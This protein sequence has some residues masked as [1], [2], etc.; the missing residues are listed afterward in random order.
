MPAE[1]RKPTERICESCGRTEVW[2]DD[3]DTWR[4]DD[5]PGNVYCVHEWDINGNFLP[6]EEA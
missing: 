6:V 3:A 2:N 4:V 5:D 1:L